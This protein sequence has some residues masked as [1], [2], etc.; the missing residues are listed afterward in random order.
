VRVLIELHAGRFAA[1]DLGEDVLAVVGGGHRGSWSK[2]A[3]PPLSRSLAQGHAGASA[4]E[5]G[6]RQTHAPAKRLERHYNP[7]FRPRK[8]RPAELER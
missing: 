7:H 8:S 4:A 5:S 1:Q 6:V 2:D 3:E